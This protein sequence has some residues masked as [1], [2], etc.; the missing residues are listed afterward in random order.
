M[1]NSSMH[2]KTLSVVLATYNE[3]ANLAG[4]LDSIKDLADE[5]VIVDGTSSDKTVEIAKKYNAIVKSYHQ[6]AKFPH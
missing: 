4:C 6:Q 5:V 3:E 1:I 2:R